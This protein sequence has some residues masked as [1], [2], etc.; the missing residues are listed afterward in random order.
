[1]L[2]RPYSV[3]EQGCKEYV[4][5]RSMLDIVEGGF[6]RGTR[7]N[8]VFPASRVLARL[9]GG[10]G[11]AP[12]KLAARDLLIRTTSADESATRS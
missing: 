11:S 1:M 2:L 7:A 4:E 10:H 9:S 3:R 5:R 12:F 6:R 8:G